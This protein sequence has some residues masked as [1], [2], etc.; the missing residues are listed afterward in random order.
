MD[1]IVRALC[2]IYD[3]GIS[4]PDELGGYQ[5]IVDGEL[6]AIELASIQSQL[7][8]EIALIDAADE[9]FEQFKLLRDTDW[10]VTKI[11]EAVIDA[12]QTEVDALKVKYA[13]QLQQ[14]K[15][16]RVAINAYE[17]SL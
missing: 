2:K 9:Y 4:G 3:T 17:A 1:K 11:S 10:I 15:D 12:N 16:T 14:R 7:D 5:R 8:A 13:T 6:V